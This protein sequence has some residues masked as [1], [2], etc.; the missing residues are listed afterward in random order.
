VERREPVGLL[1]HRIADSRRQRFELGHLDPSVDRP[2]GGAH[3]AVD[4]HR[5]EGERVLRAED[6]CPV[7]VRQQPAAAA[8]DE[9]RGVPRP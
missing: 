2:P 9:Q 1:G 6:R 5:T 7:P 3:L 4:E 8:V